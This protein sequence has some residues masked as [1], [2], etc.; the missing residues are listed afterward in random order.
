MEREVDTD[1][2]SA[3]DVATVDQP[4]DGC[5]RMWRWCW[6]SKRALVAFS[7]MMSMVQTPLGPRIDVPLARPGVTTVWIL[8]VIAGTFGISSIA[9]RERL[10]PLSIPAIAI[11]MLELAWVAGQILAQS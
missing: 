11:S 7:A 4:D 1:L 2:Q 8:A 6:A 3:K 10:W 9:W 5:G